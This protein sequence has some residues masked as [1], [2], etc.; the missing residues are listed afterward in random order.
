MGTAARRGG[1]QRQSLGQRS[2]RVPEKP[3]VGGLIVRAGC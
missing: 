1:A 2:R 3:V